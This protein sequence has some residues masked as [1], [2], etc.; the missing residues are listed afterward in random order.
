MELLRNLLGTFVELVGN[1]QLKLSIDSF[2]FKKYIEYTAKPKKPIDVLC[3][4]VYYL[5]P[6]PTLGRELYILFAYQPKPRPLR[7]FRP[8]N[9]TLPD[10][11]V[12][13]SSSGLGFD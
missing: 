9:I 8:L 13:A 6:R 2:F 4:H 11:L 5:M 10:C 12:L 3:G 7:T 1:F